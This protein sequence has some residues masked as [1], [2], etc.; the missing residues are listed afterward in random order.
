MGQVAITP[1][2]TGNSTDVFIQDSTSTTGA[3]KTG[4]VFNTSALTCYYTFTGASAGSVSVSLVTLA[5]VTTAWA[6]G[7]FIEIDATHMPGWYRFD[8]PNLA[9]AGGSGPEVN[10]HFQGAANMAPCPVKLGIGAA[11]LTAAQIATGIW[12]DTTSGDFTVAGSIGKS[13]Y[14]SGATPGATGGL[15]IAGTNAATAI[16]TSFTTTF[17]GNLTGSVGSVAGAVG[18][19]T[20]NV[21]GNV[22][23]TVASIVSPGNVWDVVNTGATHNVAN[24]TGKQLRTLSVGVSDVIYTA[25]L[26]S[27]AGQTST[28][29]VLDAGASAVAQAYQWDVISIVSGTDA[30]DSRII[31]NYTTGRVATVQRAWTTQPDATSVYE[32]TSTASAQVIS[33]FAGQDPATLV[34]DVLAASHNTASTIGAKINSIT[35]AP[36][37]AAVATAVWTDTTAGDFTAATSPG[38]VIF[39]QLGGAFS[40]SSSSIFSTAALANAPTGG[41]AP[42]AAQV[43]TAVW[44]D[45]TAGDFT[46]ASSIGLLLKTTGVKVAS[47]ASGQDPATL[48]LDVAQS[49]H[50]TAGTIG[51]DIGLSGGGSAPTAAQN[52]TAVWQDLLASSDFNT[53]GSIGL[54]LKT[55]INA[56]LSTLSTYAGG[57]V[58]SVTAGVTVTTNNDKGGYSLASTGL[59]AIAITAPSGLATT[60]PAM[61]VQLWRRFFKAGAKT[62]SGLTIKTFADDGTTVLTTQPYTDDGAGNETL[63][64][65]S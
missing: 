22:V 33:Y 41:A 51:A 6:S 39:T 9:V 15:F 65:G 53:A 55:D 45:A 49:G 61:V 42:T 37:A 47:Y 2:S 14:T 56:Q 3:G 11:A 1:G 46:A 54:L 52:A 57:A 36:T 27:Q 4:L 50:N 16:T 48:V 62:V 35:T 25:T 17:T 28:T 18:S 60:F 64:A 10:F 63:G 31:T 24:S 19:V 34:L 13:L 59:N 58:A 43:A 32:I 7:G 23:G 30:G 29:A 40:T 26:P 21:G 12:Q 38:K 8:I 44:Q 20:G 5:T